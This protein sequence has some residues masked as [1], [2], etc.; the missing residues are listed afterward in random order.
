MPKRS[1]SYAGGAR[2]D[3]LSNYLWNPAPLAAYHHTGYQYTKLHRPY[4][5]TQFC[6]S[7]FIDYDIHSNEMISFFNWD[8]A[9]IKQGFLSAN[10]FDNFTKIYFTMVDSW[11][12]TQQVRA[13]HFTFR[14]NFCDLFNEKFMQ[15]FYKQVNG[16]WPSEQQLEFLV[17]DNQR[18]MAAYE[19]NIEFHVASVAHRLFRFELSHGLCD[20]QRKWS[21]DDFWNQ[22]PVVNEQFLQELDSLLDPQGYHRSLT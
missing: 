10:E 8:K 22:H 17:H 6:P 2:G 12:F 9:L 21:I 1:I 11:Q 19:T 15:N 13:D 4:D 7:I 14:L 16:T 5:I 20:H 18:Q 3:F